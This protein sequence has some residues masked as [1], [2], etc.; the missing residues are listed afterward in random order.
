MTRRQRRR[1]R[2]TGH[3]PTL[4]ARSRVSRALPF[5]VGAGVAVGMALLVVVIFGGG[6]D[7]PTAAAPLLAASDDAPASAAASA[8]AARTTEQQELLALGRRLVRPASERT[9]A[10]PWEGKTRSR[11]PRRR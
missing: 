9:A 6:V 11:R 4:T 8:I 1:R 5:V 7:G 10:E 3:G 2:K